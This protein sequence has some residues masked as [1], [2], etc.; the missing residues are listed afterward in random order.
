MKKTKR[1]AVLVIIAFLLILG[2]AIYTA[3]FGVADRGKV[4]Y[5]KLGL[6]LKGGLS[7]TYEI[8]MITATRISRIPSIRLSSV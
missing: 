1:N 6:D 8:Q 3:I 4:E 2:V 5:I 7:V